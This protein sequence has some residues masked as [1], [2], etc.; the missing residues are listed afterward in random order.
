[1]Q[2]AE[3]DEFEAQML[4]LCAGK[5]VPV[6]DRLEA[7]WIGL[8]QMSI[9]QFACVVEYALGEEGPE[10]IPTTNQV[11]SIHKQLRNRCTT[12]EQPQLPAIQEAEH[13]EFLANQLL[14]MVISDRGGLGSTGRFIP[15]NGVVDCTASAELTAALKAKHDVAALF[16]EVICEQHQDA[17][18]F[19]FIRTF[20]IALEQVGVRIE[21][22]TLSRW[23]TMMQH[24]SA[25]LQF[26]EFMGRNRAAASST[27]LQA[28]A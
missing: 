5:N 26:P 23:R 11:W 1:M 13:I 27:A 21:Q 24:P 12:H 25:K 28:R 6:G 16:A 3:R 22:K 9:A 4:M 18:P 15:G 2:T 10:K 19:E 14:W 20:K 8:K 17:T 7:Y